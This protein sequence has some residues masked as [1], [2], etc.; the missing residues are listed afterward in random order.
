MNI[1][2]IRKLT[3]TFS[4]VGNELGLNEQTLARDVSDIFTGKNVQK[5]SLGRQLGLDSEDIEQAKASAEG[6]FAFLEDRLKGYAEA[7]ENYKN[8]MAGALSH[9]EGMAT[10][11]SATLTSSLEPAITAVLN[12]TADFFGTITEIS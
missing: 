2:Q 9:L 1:G 8:T 4:T 5:T 11:A 12:T 3:S 7:N 10:Y 6:L